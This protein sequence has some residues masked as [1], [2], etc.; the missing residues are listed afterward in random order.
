LDLGKVEEIHITFEQMTTLFKNLGFVVAEKTSKKREESLL[1]SI[2]N[3]VG[4]EENPI[5]LKNVKAVMCCILNFHVD[6]YLDSNE[7]P[8]NPH[9]LGTLR[10]NSISFNENEILHITKKY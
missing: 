7:D 6:W 9:H 2:W 5:N 1:E 3:L 10:E 8:V 4:G